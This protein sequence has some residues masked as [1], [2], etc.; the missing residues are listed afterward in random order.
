M[1]VAVVTV[2]RESV[3]T[4]TSRMRRSMDVGHD[5]GHRTL[6]QWQP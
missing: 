2:A 5:V 4:E 3:S 1:R 6:P